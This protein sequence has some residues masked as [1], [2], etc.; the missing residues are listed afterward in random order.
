M[1]KHYRIW[2]RIAIVCWLFIMSTI[3]IL[4]LN[5]PYTSS[6]DSVERAVIILLVGI[7]SLYCIN[8]Y[9]DEI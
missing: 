3:N 6:F 7:F 9:F 5:M 8:Y 1:Q 2:Y 4:N